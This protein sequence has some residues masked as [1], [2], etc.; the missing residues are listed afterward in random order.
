MKKIT[1]FERKIDGLYNGF[2]FFI[3]IVGGEVQF[4]PLD[5]A[6]TDRPIVPAWVIMMMEKL[7][8]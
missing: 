5:T 4:G 3:G 2:D 8:E 6:A 7:V 1:L